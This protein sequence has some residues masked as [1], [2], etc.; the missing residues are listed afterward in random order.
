MVGKNVRK[1]ASVEDLL[2][3]TGSENSQDLTNRLKLL[4]MQDRN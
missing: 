2:A 4:I 3:V 1:D